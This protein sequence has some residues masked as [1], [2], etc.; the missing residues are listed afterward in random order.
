MKELIELLKQISELAGVGI[1]AL[2]SADGGD[3]NAE[4][5]QGK[6][7]EG[8]N[9]PGPEGGAPMMHHQGGQAQPPGRFGS[10]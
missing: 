2:K 7:P 10:R 9:E 5:E 1:D 6:G 3:K 8:P 4:P